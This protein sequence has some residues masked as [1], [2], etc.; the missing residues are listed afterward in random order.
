MGED[1]S[2]NDTMLVWDHH[3]VPMSP[4]RMAKP[5][6]NAPLLK[7]IIRYPMQMEPH[8]P[9]RVQV[10]DASRPEPVQTKRDGVDMVFKLPREARDARSPMATIDHALEW[11]PHPF[12]R[13][14][15]ATEEDG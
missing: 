3:P 4:M 10:F 13:R 2:F 14:R 12:G 9:V 5:E 6:P 11:R 7:R 8:A 1:F 15:R